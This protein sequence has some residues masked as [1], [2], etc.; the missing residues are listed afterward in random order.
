MKKFFLLLMSLVLSFHSVISQPDPIQY[1]PAEIDFSEKLF[2]WDGFGFN[3]VEAAQTRD[4]KESP[5]DYG[6][7]SYLSPE[8]KEEVLNLIFGNEGLKVQII[9]MFLD[10]YHQDQPGGAFDHE[11]TTRN[12][13][14]FVRKGIDLTKKNNDKIEII[15]TLYGPPAWA[16][17]Q[18]F[19]GGRDLDTTMILPLC[20]YLVHWTD[21]LIKRDF[22]VKYISLHNEGEDFYRWNFN[23]GTQRLEKFDYNMYWPPEQV[24]CFLNEMPAVLSK[25][26]LE[27]VGVTNGEPSNW[28]RFYYWGYTDALYNDKEALNNL[29]LL[30]T[31][32]FINGDLSKL[33]YGV[34]NSLTTDKLHT[35]KPD[36]HAWVT[37]M[38]WGNMG[39]DF[40]RMVHENI[41]SAK[42]NAIIPWAGIQE[43]TAW[44]SGDPN[45]GCAISVSKKGTYEVLKGYYF[46]KQLTRA[47]RR[48]MHIAKASLANPQAFIIAF[49]GAESLNPD[50]FVVSSNIRI[51][52]LPLKIDLKGTKSTKFMAYR[53][54]EEGTELFKEIGVFAIEKGAIVYDPPAGT[55]TTFIAMD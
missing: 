54:N 15:T 14:E 8:K 4:Y 21:Y 22:P 39:V 13:R 41:Y 27:N 19:I 49:S 44:I 47:G 17:K 51:W 40:I 46:Y 48:G 7:F 20:D 50:A 38:S 32:G 23:E 33:S 34:A 9:K 42:V 35:K 31:H 5:Q 10:P 52:S 43:P 18:K 1:I 53:T 24:N 55:T 36:L 11:W 25:Y 28:T 30:T 16:S 6:G 37:S 3:Y 45:P 29:G 26:N 2:E 12:M